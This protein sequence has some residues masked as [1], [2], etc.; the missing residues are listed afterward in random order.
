MRFALAGSPASYRVSLNLVAVFR[1]MLFVDKSFFLERSVVR[2]TPALGVLRG[3]YGN[4]ATHSGDKFR[5]R[6]VDGAH[7]LYGLTNRIGPGAEA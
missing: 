7:Y 3:C 1:A 4:E 2:E 6:P 5:E